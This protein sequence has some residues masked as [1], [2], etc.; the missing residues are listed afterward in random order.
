[1]ELIELNKSNIDAREVPE[2]DLC[3]SRFFCAPIYLP[4]ILNFRKTYRERRL[5]ESR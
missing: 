1:M 3:P 2:P 4:K 5:A